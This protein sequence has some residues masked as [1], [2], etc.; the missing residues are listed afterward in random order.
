MVCYPLRSAKAAKEHLA[1]C[2]SVRHPA[3]S[4]FPAPALVCPLLDRL[5]ALD[6]CR[7]PGSPGRNSATCRLFGLKTP[8]RNWCTG[9]SS[10]LLERRSLLRRDLL[11]GLQRH[12]SIRRSE[13]ACGFRHS[14]SVLSVPRHLPRPIRNAPGGDGKPEK[15]L[16]PASGD[17]RSFSLGGGRTSKDP[18][19]RLPLGSA[20]HG[21][22]RQHPPCA[23]GNGHRC[24]WTFF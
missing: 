24:V 4:D 22:G 1:T 16:E 11:P 3:N 23:R 20:G 2:D 17:Y 21:S 13:F 14:D 18:H 6:L 7:T 15:A 19:H 8:A 10:P 12:A 9:L 5:I